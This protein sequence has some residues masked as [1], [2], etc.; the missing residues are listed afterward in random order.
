MNKI[1]RAPW[2]DYT[3]KCI[4]MVTINK[5]PL[6]P[7]FG[8]LEGDHRLPVGQKGSSFVSASAIGS[9][10]KNV[11]RNF[12]LIEPNIRILQYSLMPDHLHILLFVEEPT[13]EIL[14][15]IIARFKVDVDKSAGMEKVFAKG[16]NDQILKPSRSLDTIYRYIRSNPYRL[17][18][19]RAYPDF[20]RR[21]YGV[22]IGGKRYQT[23]GN[24][25]LLRNPF[26]EQ[27]VVHRRDSE[28]TR[29]RNRELWLHTAANG[30]VLV[31]PFISPAEKEIRQEAEESGGKIILITNLPFPDRYKP[32]EHDFALCLA[33]RLLIISPLDPPATPDLSRTACLEMNNLA[34][35]IMSLS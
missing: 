32:A 19:R 25:F 2:H 18:V 5:S 17:A 16:F 13:E 7:A 14:G 28:Q 20:F 9:A 33:G 35:V 29:A 8:T 27:V 34:S 6:I 15:R 23:Y 30:G 22:T 31:S 26:K 24:Q 11:L 3:Q 4:Y 21:V 1:L 12:R 10:I